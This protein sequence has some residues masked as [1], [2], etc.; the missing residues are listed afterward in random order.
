V[1]ELSGVP[2]RISVWFGPVDGS[3]PWF[4]RLVDEPHYPASLM[5]VPLLVAAHRAHEAGALDL[6]APVPVRNRF[7]SALPGAP[8]FALRDAPENDPSVWRLLGGSASLRWLV[9]RMIVASSNLAANIVLGYVGADR[10]AEVWR[11]AGAVASATPRGIEDRAARDAGVDNTVTAAD[12][13]R[14]LSALGTGRLAGPEATGRM[15]DTLAAREHREDLAAG[16]PAGTRVAFKNGWVHGVRHAAGIVY[17]TDSDPYALVVCA[18]TP[19]A[20]VC[21]PDGRDEGCRLVA[22]IAAW[23]WERRSGRAS[24]ARPDHA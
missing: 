15:L 16:L 19:L 12:L 10:V 21:G 1:N 11:L 23:S 8:Q 7:A 5:K 24:A 9:E 2:G 22:S 20:G 3:P 18:T 6:D 13:A 4:G 17:P 14:L